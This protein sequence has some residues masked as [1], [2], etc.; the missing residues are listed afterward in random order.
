MVSAEQSAYGSV[1]YSALLC[2]H[3]FNDFC[4]ITCRA[5][6]QNLFHY[7]PFYWVVGAFQFKGL[8]RVTVVAYAF[9][10]RV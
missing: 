5:I 3:F 8:E 9:P 4:Y 2:F 7:S 6:T 10:S 1:N